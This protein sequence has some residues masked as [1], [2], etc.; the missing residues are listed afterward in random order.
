MIEIDTFIEYLLVVCFFC[1][2]CLLLPYPRREI[3]ATPVVSPTEPIEAKIVVE[4]NPVDN[5]GDLPSY[6]EVAKTSAN[7]L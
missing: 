6:S 2:V 4:D 7:K 3:E 1:M 5:E